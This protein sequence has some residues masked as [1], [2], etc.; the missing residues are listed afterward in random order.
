MLMRVATLDSSTQGLQSHLTLS[1]IRHENGLRFA[2]KYLEA[3]TW[4]K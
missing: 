4:T 3:I 1:G 2:R